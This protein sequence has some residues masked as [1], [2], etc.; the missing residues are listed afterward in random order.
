VD[1]SAYRIAQEAMTNALKHGGT[2][3]IAVVTFL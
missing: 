2:G 1:L 3:I